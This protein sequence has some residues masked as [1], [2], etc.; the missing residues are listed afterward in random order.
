MYA[1]QSA[2]EI[3]HKT[4]CSIGPELCIMLEVNFREY[5][6]HELG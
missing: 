6:N 3:L 2:F 4:T 1:R 5:L